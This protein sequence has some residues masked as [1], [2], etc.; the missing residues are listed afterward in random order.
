MGH[1]LW[2]RVGL[3]LAT[4][5]LMLPARPVVGAEPVRL[6]FD[7]DLGADI[8][9]ALALAILHAG[10][11]RRVCRLLAVTL[12]NDD[13]RVAPAV[14]A[15]NT[16][17]GHPDIP[18]GAARNGIGSVTRYVE[19]AEQR[20]G[21][22]L[23]FPHR[24]RSGKDLPDAVSLLRR[25]LAEQP[26]GSVV[27]V[28]VGLSSNLAALLR[29]GPDQASPLGGADLV[30]HKVKLLSV[31]GGAFVPVEG[32]EHY[33]EYNI[34]TDLPASRRL[35]ADW[36]TPVVWSGF[37]IGLAIPYPAA[38]IEHDFGYVEHHPIAEAYRLYGK[39]PFD[40]PTW[41][42]TAVLYALFPDRGYFDLSPRGRV[43]VEADGSTSFARDANG[44]HR[45]LILR[46]GQRGRAREALVQLTSQPPQ[47]LPDKE[48]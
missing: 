37:E 26:D 46:P 10:Q 30:K 20:D 45:Y 43:T 4:T 16:F 48:R 11:A 14:D 21:G 8:D 19:I 27:I 34:K 22:R 41:D 15:I 13:P 28:Q 2:V 38:S 29:T 31:M 33:P 1:P 35:A 3:L 44:P 23:R 24:V 42:L 39:M 17:Y 36:P 18:I 40:R 9:D 25:V 5:L 7:T 47:T 6:V 12:T 32:N